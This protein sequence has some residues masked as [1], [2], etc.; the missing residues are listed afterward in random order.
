MLSMAKQRQERAGLLQARSTCSS[1]GHLFMNRLTAIKES[2]WKQ[3]S[4]AVD[5]PARFRE[6]QIE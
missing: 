2:Q 5:V 3:I 1:C 4:E 6:M